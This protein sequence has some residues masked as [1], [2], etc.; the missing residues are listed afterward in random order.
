VPLSPRQIRALLTDPALQVHDNPQAFLACNYD[1]AKA[2]CHPDRAAGAATGHPSLDRCNPACANIARTDTHI[3]AL[4]A[5]TTRL[6]IEI[7]SPLT[8]GPIRERL[9]QRAASLEQIAQRHT[10][11]RITS[12][13]KDRH[14]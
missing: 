7:T 11:T 3:T 8:P 10:R 14:G 2:L 5:E 1:P 12:P 9:T 13:P 4:T 6:Q